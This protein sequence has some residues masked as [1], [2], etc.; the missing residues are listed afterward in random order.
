M[1]FAMSALLLVAVNTSVKAP[2]GLEIKYWLIG[3]S[4]ILALGSLISIIGVDIE[5]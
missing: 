3:M 5:R 2:Y 1:N 4:I